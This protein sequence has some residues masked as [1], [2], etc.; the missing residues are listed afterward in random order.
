MNKLTTRHGIA[1]V[2]EIFKPFDYDKGGKACAL[3]KLDYH[4]FKY[5]VVFNRK[6]KGAYTVAAFKTQLLGEMFL[7]ELAMQAE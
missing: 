7:K 6:G 2:I 5:H 4:D 1:D 3:V